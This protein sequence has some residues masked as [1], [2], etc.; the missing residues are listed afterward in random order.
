MIRKNICISL[1]PLTT[2]ILEESYR[3]TANK[4][5]LE[6]LEFFQND[7]NGREN[8]KKKFNGPFA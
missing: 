2:V 7:G 3:L 5:L 4:I 1:K 6:F 8:T